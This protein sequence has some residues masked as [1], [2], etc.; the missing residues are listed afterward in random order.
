MSWLWAD[1]T[2]SRRHFEQT[3]LWAATNLSRHFWRYF[4]HKILWADATLSR[5]HSWQKD[6]SWGDKTLFK[7]L[8]Y[9]M[10]LVFWHRVCGHLSHHRSK[11]GSKW[12]KDEP[13]PVTQI[14]DPKQNCVTL[15]ENLVVYATNAW[16]SP[17]NA[18]KCARAY[19]SYHYCA[20]WKK[21]KK[22]IHM[23]TLHRD[24]IC[25]VSS[26]SVSGDVVCVTNVL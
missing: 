21:K 23:S 2:F 20:S 8:T 12:T 25:Q 11:Y 5:Q 9:I 3:T 22:A 19:N 16:Y 26:K 10:F 7:V 17:I 18:R 4:H 13:M 1:D 6:D 24:L 14:C 15:L